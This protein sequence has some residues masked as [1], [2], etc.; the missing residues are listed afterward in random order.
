M[1]YLFSFCGKSQSS[2]WKF[3]VTEDVLAYARTLV[4]RIIV[5]GGKI[6]LILTIACNKCDFDLLFNTV[7]KWK[8]IFED[9][10]KAGNKIKN[11]KTK[12]KQV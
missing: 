4:T 5:S 2:L 12:M 1:L 8:N 9:R 10:L 7:G 3:V 11:R 6:L